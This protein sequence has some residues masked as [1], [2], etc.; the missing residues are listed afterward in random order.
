M[1]TRDSE[2]RM[3]Q[4]AYASIKGYEPSEWRRE[5]VRIGWSK[6]PMLA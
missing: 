2:D 1:D 6:R 4:E 3:E 5:T